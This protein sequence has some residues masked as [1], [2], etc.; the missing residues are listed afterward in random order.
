[1]KCPFINKN[2]LF[3]QLSYKDNISTFFINF[4]ECNYIHRKYSI[5][6]FTSIYL[7]HGVFD[8]VMYEDIMI[9]K[10]YILMITIYLFFS[11]Y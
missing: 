11:E 10:S 8:F 3:E 4:N 7:N 2:L 9:Y 1:M 5:Q 6:N